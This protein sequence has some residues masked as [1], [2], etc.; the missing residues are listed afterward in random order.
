[1]P[2]LPHALASLTPTT[3]KCS[4]GQPCDLCCIPAPPGDIRSE[5]RSGPAEYRLL[6]SLV[7]RQK[8]PSSVR[9]HHPFQAAAILLPLPSKH[10]SWQG[11][12]LGTASCQSSLR[13]NY[14]RLLALA[15]ACRGP[16]AHKTHRGPGRVKA[17]AAHGGA[18][19]VREVW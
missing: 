14:N 12:Y 15:S 6:M 18:V 5:T 4:G 19:K 1:M 11:M 10:G 8:A 9:S 16:S 2:G 3:S 7:A 13:P 17:P